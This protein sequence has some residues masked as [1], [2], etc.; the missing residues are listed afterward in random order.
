MKKAITA[1]AALMI[2]FTG[3]LNA[4][5]RYFEVAEKFY[6][7]GK[8]MLAQKL[9][10]RYLQENPATLNDRAYFYLG[11]LY[12][13]KKQYEYAIDQYLYASELNNEEAAYF[14]NMA[15][16]YYQIEA[17]SNAIHF[18]KK[19]IN[20][21]AKQKL[22]KFPVTNI[23]DF[24]EMR[25]REK[26]KLFVTNERLNSKTASKEK[27]EV[28]YA[29]PYLHMGHCYIKRKEYVNAAASYEIFMA[30]V[31]KDYRQYK[32]IEAV[33]RRIKKS[34]DIKIEE[35]ESAGETNAL[36]PTNSPAANPS[37]TNVSAETNSSETPPTNT[38]HESEAENTNTVK[39][40]TN[41]SPSKEALDGL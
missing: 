22:L 24:Y 31:T 20:T 23:E 8:F 28:F 17:Y 40:S 2:L 16:C 34:F 41:E 18:Y 29:V 14:I 15:N 21:L 11:N 37:N 6:Q 26:E 10:E 5:E 12:F 1:F 7:D 33:V 32:E 35:D 39:S 36:T 9:L 4:D 13:S 38:S 3:V 25:E 30:N 27:V 19:S